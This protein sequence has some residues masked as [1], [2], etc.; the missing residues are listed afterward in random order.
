MT[1]T[2]QLRTRIEHESLSDVKVPA[3]ALYS[4]QAQRAVE[5]YAISGP[6]A[7]SALIRAT[8]LVKK[9]AAFANRDTGRL[10]P[11]LAAAIGQA[12]DEILGDT[13]TSPD[14]PLDEP[15]RDHF[16]VDIY[17][18]G[19]GTSHN[20][21]VNE[22]LA[23]RVVEILRGK[24]GEYK[25]RLPGDDPDKPTPQHPNDHVNMAQSTNAMFPT[26]MRVDTL[27]RI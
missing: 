12:A 15:W 16:V 2:Q 10:D 17:Q 13:K 25:V 9:A 21:N 8:L 6:H 27:L 19:A 1:T 22:V 26:A 11:R 7:H 24:R 4:A 20:M 5:N 14:A 23:N 3:D 18:A